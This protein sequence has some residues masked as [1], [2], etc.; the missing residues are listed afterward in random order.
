M[1]LRTQLKDTKIRVIEI[2]PPQ[3]GTDLHRE[4]A[5]PDDNKK[6]KNPNSL[7]VEEFMEDVTKAWENEEETIG[8]G[9][10]IKVI[11]R[12]YKEF[13]ADYEKAAGTK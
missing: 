12:W 8:A 4:R 1:N 6:D 11:D 9:S 7:S 3:V 2:A 5:D 13:G 10:S